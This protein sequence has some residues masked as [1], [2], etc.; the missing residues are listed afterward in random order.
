MEDLID[1]GAVARILG[2]SPYAVRGMA[3]RGAL[4]AYK[5]GGQWRFKPTEIAAWVDDQQPE[6]ERPIPP[7]PV[8]PIPLPLPRRQPAPDPRQAVRDARRT[9]A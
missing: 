1:V 8:G 9:A 2:F 5:I 6:P 7:S 3:K 4:P